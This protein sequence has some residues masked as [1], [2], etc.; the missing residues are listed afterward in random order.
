MVEQMVNSKFSKQVVGDC[1]SK[2]PS[3]DKQP[4][5]T[6]QNTTS[7]DVQ[8]DNQNAI[9]RHLGN[10]TSQREAE[11]AVASPRAIPGGILSPPRLQSV[12]STVAN[13]QYVYARRKSD[14]ELSNGRNSE[15]NYRVNPQPQA[16]IKEPNG[17]DVSAFAPIPMSSTA[18][19]CESL[20]LLIDPLRKHDNG[21]PTVVKSDPSLDDSRLTGNQ[22]W[23]DRFIQLQTYLK[24]CNSNQEAY[25]KKLRSFTSD[26]CSRQAV[27]LERRAIHLMLEEG[28]TVKDINFFLGRK[29]Q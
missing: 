26:E 7:R 28:K 15:K 29:T 13:Q 9:S 24:H 25:V 17:D 23:R 1:G 20:T 4:L 19:S 18:T 27:E 5:I 3:F 12:G 22:H 21:L 6:P 2:L 10:F 14:A 8:N 11:S 16:K